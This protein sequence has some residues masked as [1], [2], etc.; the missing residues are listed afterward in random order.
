MIGFIILLGEMESE[1]ERKEGVRQYGVRTGRPI[2]GC[3]VVVTQLPCFA[4]SVN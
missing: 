4:H 2:Y 3:F 1:R